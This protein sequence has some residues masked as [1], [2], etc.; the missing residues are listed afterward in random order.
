MFVFVLLWRDRANNLILG[1]FLKMQCRYC[2]DCTCFCIDGEEVDVRL[3]ILFYID[4]IYIFIFF[5][6][7][8]IADF[9]FCFIQIVF[10]LLFLLI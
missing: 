10:V 7:T 5:I 3:P 9:L 6:S 2:T 4:C 1:F 8:N